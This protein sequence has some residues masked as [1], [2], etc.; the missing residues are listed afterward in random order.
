MGRADLE[1]NLFS[2]SNV[3]GLF[4][5]ECARFVTFTLNSWVSTG[6][7]VKI[8]QNDYSIKFYL[9]PDG[10]SFTAPILKSQTHSPYVSKVTTLWPLKLRNY[11]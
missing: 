6:K 5:Y 11:L 7:I 8:Y 10:F 4:R 1:L 3:C 9:K 2:L